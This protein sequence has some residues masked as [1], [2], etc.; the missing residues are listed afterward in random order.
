MSRSRSA[1]TLQLRGWLFEV[2]TCYILQSRN[3]IPCPQQP[4]ISLYLFIISAV[5]VFCYAFLPYIFSVISGLSIFSRNLC[6]LQCKTS[7]EYVVFESQTLEFK[8]RH[9]RAQSSL[10]YSGSQTTEL[11]HISLMGAGMTSQQFLKHVAQ[12]QSQSQNLTL[13]VRL[14]LLSTTYFRTAGKQGQK[15]FC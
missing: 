14:D 6:T 1:Q 10:L 4:C 9:K 13:A 11:I 7:D 8:F 5:S 15:S 3:L 2:H 12:L